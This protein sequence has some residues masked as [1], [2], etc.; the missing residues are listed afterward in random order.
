MSPGILRL[1]SHW[2]STFATDAA[3]LF[4]VTLAFI[5]PSP[6]TFTVKSLPVYAHE[7]IQFLLKKQ[8]HVPSLFLSLLITHAEDMP[9]V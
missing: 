6:V 1:R 4:L 5:L 7:Q 2:L 9:I 3:V 8:K